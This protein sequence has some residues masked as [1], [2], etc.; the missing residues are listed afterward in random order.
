MATRTV[1]IIDD[2]LDPTIEAT[3]KI[4]FAVDNTWYEIDL[5]DKHQAEFHKAIKKYVDAAR[6]VPA[7]AAKKTAAKK[8]PAAPKSEPAEPV[9]G[10]GANGENATGHSN[11]EIRDWARSAGIEVPTRGRLPGEVIAQFAEAHQEPDVA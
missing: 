9:A 1:Q 4:K 3:G 8:S 2:D 6:K 10:V 5:S 11:R 7:S